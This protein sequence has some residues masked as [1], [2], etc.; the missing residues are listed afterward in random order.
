MVAWPQL[1]LLFTEAGNGSRAAQALLLKCT[2]QVDSFAI[3]AEDED[4][5][6]RGHLSKKCTN[7][8]LLN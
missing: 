5:A 2:G 3:P 8:Q 4:W 7:H 6:F 1:L